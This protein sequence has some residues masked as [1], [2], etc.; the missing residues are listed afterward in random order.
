MVLYLKDWEF[1]W[2]DFAV[3]R[4]TENRISVAKLQT[5]KE[6]RG[7][8]MCIRRDL[9]ALAGLCVPRLAFLVLNS[10][11][12]EFTPPL[13]CTAPPR[14]QTD[15]QRQNVCWQTKPHNSRF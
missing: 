10:P 12:R 1:G 11:H 3:S 7:D 15:R 9:C 14:A 13:L 4:G 2:G 8:K 6:Q 5:P